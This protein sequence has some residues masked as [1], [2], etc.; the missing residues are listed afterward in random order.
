MLILLKNA[1]IQ[2]K[3]PN[4]RNELGLNGRKAYENRYS[5]KIMEKRLLDAIMMKMR[6]E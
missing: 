1:I 5:W 2:L 3:D 6:I 4:L